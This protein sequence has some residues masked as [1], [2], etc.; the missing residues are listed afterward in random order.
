MCGIFYSKLEVHPKQELL[1]SVETK[2]TEQ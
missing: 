1:D 2:Q